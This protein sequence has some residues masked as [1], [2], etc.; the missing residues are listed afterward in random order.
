MRSHATGPRSST[1]TSA[2]T[3]TRAYLPKAQAEPVRRLVADLRRRHG[4]RDR[5]SPK[6]EPRPPAEQ[7]ALAV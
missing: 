3:A 2:S 7:L 1:G 5:R 4:I 6:L